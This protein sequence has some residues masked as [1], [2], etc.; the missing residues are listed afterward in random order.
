ML[1]TG[2][3]MAVGRKS[4]YNYYN[5]DYSRWNLGHNSKLSL[6]DKKDLLR[7]FKKTAQDRMYRL[8]KSKVGAQTAK[9]WKKT[10]NFNIKEMSESDINFKIAQVASFLASDRSTVSGIK[11]ISKKSI[12]TLQERGYDVTEENYDD[13]I[14]FMNS[15]GDDFVPSQVIA[16]FFSKATSQGYNAKQ[17][18]QAFKKWSE[19]KSKYKKEIIEMMK[20]GKTL[21]DEDVERIMERGGRRGISAEQRREMKMNRRNKNTRNKSNRRSM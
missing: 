13:F 4:K 6:E 15:R 12:S 21:T 9:N 5:P 3:N 2:G 20:T 1:D 16:N 18:N 10:L 17:I 7:K 19:D 8:E 11:K 14:D